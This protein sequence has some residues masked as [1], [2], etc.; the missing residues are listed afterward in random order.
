MATERLTNRYQVIDLIYHPG[1]NLPGLKAKSPLAAKLDARDKDITALMAAYC[2]L[3]D[4]FP[5]DKLQQLYKLLSHSEPLDEQSKEKQP[6]K[7]K[8]SAS[9]DNEISYITPL[10]YL[11]RA[12]GDYTEV[13]GLRELLLCYD[14]VE[15]ENTETLI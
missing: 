14:H 9:L 1:N 3:G 13:P 10:A 5:K 12:Y 7:K 11:A 6:R 8:V 4:S 15:G 2:A